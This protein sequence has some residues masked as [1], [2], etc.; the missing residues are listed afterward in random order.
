MH[1]MFPFKKNR[2]FPYKRMRSEDFSRELEYM[3]HK[4]QFLNRW[5]FGSGIAF[6]LQVQ[7]LGE[8]ALM[9][10]QGMAVDRQGRY[11][12]VDEP[13]VCQI[14]T[15][16]NFNKI[17]GDTALL[18]LRYQEKWQ[19]AWMV[20]GEDGEHQEFFVSAEHYELY[21][22]EF[23]TEALD[24]VDKV[25]YFEQQLYMDS[26]IRIR[27]IMPD[28]LSSCQPM[29]IRLVFE[30]LT[31]EKMPVQWHY[32]PKLPGF[33]I[34]ESQELCAEGK[35][36]LPVGE[37]VID[38]LLI[39][40]TS[41]QSVRFTMKE[42]D[43][44]I[45]LPYKEAGLAEQIEHEFRI[46]SEDP[47]DDLAG[48]LRSMSVQ[49]LWGQEDEAGVPLA[50]LRLIRCEDEVL[51][52]DIIP[53]YQQQTAHLP[54]LEQ[55]IQA[56]REFFPVRQEREKVAEENEPIDEEQTV[57]S[58]G[59]QYMTTGVVSLNAGLHLHK[60]KILCTG[61]ILHNLGPGT[62]YMDFGIEQVLPAANEDRNI[63]NILLGDPS[64]FLSEEDSQW[65][66][67]KGIRIHPEKGT[68]ELALRLEKELHESTLQLRWY[69]WRAEKVAG[70]SKEEGTL[71]RLEP[72]VIY[73]EPG[74]TIYFTPIFR[75]NS[76]PC[77][78]FVEKKQAGQITRD[79]VYTAPETEGLY[80]V[81]AQVQEHPE[82][83]IGAFIIVRIQEEGAENESREI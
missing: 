41:A 50:V 31:P 51:L 24:T 75:G 71:L 26:C 16:E 1:T 9:V 30:N 63:C 56:C 44:T 43:F 25:L 17:V 83:K 38:L 55:R 19:D 34:S 11:L 42:E 14:K 35:E 39:P 45:Q 12:I 72:D 80:Q 10:S 58:D 73:A 23:C 68:F 76:K 54:A 28:V 5:T 49:E 15:L 57:T 70:Y 48:H 7:R 4:L 81:C 77:E 27:Q 18:W 8:E 6:G 60:G 79:G 52:G 62:V 61:E 64:L 21:A 13:A 53:V 22:T 78:F 69:A 2:Y 36:E 66:F 74:Q 82:T 37:S 46:V 29:K 3:D 47:M 32:A 20:P 40:E 59:E 67:D 65:A 33:H